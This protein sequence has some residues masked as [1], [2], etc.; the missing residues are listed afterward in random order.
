MPW[1]LGKG[2]TSGLGELV[3]KGVDDVS[4]S[5]QLFESGSDGASAPGPRS[6]PPQY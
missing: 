5:S 3:R 4:F 6:V 2:L 1:R